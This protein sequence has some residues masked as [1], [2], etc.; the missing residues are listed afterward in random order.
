MS[1]E[2][3]WEDAPLV[4]GA[5]SE[6]PWEAAPLVGEEDRG[7]LAFINRAIAGT[8]GAPV[9][10]AKGVLGLG[11]SERGREMLGASEAVGGAESITRGFQAADIT[12][13]LPS[14]QPETLREQ[15]G[16]GV[17]EATSMLIPFTKAAQLSSKSATTAGRVSKVIWDG[18]RKH[19][20]LTFGTEATA[21]AGTGAG[22]ELAEATD[23][24]GLRTAFELGGGILGGLTP[25]ALTYTPAMVGGRLTKTVLKKVIPPFTKAGTKRRAQAFVQK[26]VVEPGGAASQAVSDTIGELPPVVATGEDRLL[27]LMHQIQGADPTKDADMIRRLT[28]SAYQ[29]E[30]ELRGLGYGAP[31][32]LQN[33]T[34][35]RVA[36][37]ELDM[38]KRVADAMEIADD[39]LS[40]LPV[41]KRQSEESRIVRSELEKVARVADDDLKRDWAR[42]RKDVPVEITYIG[43][44]GLPSGARQA[45]LDLL[46]ETPKAQLEDIPTVLKKSFLANKKL[47]GPTSVKEAQG[48]R[49][50]LLEVQRISSADGKFNKARMAGDMADELLKDMS[51]VE[52]NEALTVAIA[53]TRK[54][55]QRFNQGIVGKI[56]GRAKTGEPAVSPDLTLD[57]SVG[58][59]GK[60]GIKGTVDLDKVVITPEARNATRRYLSRSFTDFVTAKGTKNFDIKQARK[61][62]ATN[63]EV[64]D[65]FPELRTE[66]S[67]ISSAQRHA[68]DTLATMQARRKRIEDPKLSTTALFLEADPGA[69]VDAVFKSRNPMK[70]TQDLINK[71]RKDPSGEAMEG[72][73]GAYIDHLI[74]KSSDGFFNDLGEQTIAGKKLLSLFNQNKPIYRQLLD[75]EEIGRLRKIAEE[76]VKVDKARGGVPKVGDRPDD[77]PSNFLNLVGGVGGAQFGRW[78]ARHT[79]GGTVQTPGIISGRVKSFLNNLTK[80]NAYKL[81]EEALVADD[82]GKLL[83]AL[84]LPIDQPTT[85]QGQKNMRELNARLNTWLIGTGSRIIRDI[86]EQERIDRQEAR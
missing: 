3:P 72:L 22:R 19:P 37:L 6:K 8:L 17:G 78:V 12:T 51:R 75:P 53:S 58:R 46:E 11:L 54:F 31:E 1:A 67:D 13:A 9:D 30:L 28:H 18:I 26:Q 82:G 56:L 20:F 32:V 83:Q 59:G 23:R 42:V 81:V 86:E 74:R 48:L 7:S 65:Q 29:L 39:K 70:T 60:T 35:K 57:V 21:G 25:V 77:A 61:W 73:K 62:L 4:S 45:Y 38:D 69:E 63:E 84:L 33:I 66:L 36:S 50:K 24:P 15:V 27:S 49:S 5:D 64:L 76:F 41:A 2:K 52:G 43:E 79:G 14:E 68:S 80:G 55:K 71:A 10:V 40:A 16:A 47:K 85:V 44:D 34:R